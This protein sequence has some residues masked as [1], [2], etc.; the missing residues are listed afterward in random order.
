MVHL[1]YTKPVRL[2]HDDS[3]QLGHDNLPQLFLVKGGTLSVG[4][5]AMFLFDLPCAAVIHG[6]V[7]NRL[8]CSQNERRTQCLSKLAK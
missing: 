7:R 5:G 8:S 4:F 1:Y 3:F 2:I 6:T